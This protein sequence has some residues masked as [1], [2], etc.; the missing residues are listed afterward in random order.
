MGVHLPSAEELRRRG[1]EEAAGGAVAEVAGVD[2]LTAVAA[3]LHDLLLE[4]AARYLE[5]R[6]PLTGCEAHRGPDVGLDVPYI[7]WVDGAIPVSIPGLTGSEG[8]YVLQPSYG[9][10]AVHVQRL[11]TFPRRYWT[12]ES[13]REPTQVT[14]VEK[15]SYDRGRTRL[16][17]VSARQLVPDTRGKADEWLAEVARSMEAE[18]VSSQAHLH[19]PGRR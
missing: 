15:S 18:L 7:A 2:E 13:V 14:L 3:D 1:H 17:Y 16:E 10:Y 11:K 19:L 9:R 8:V 5:L 12:E 6:L 4:Y